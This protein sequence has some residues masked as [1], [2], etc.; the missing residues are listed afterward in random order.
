MVSRDSRCDRNRLK[1]FL[2]GDSPEGSHAE[3]LRH[4]DDCKVCQQELERLAADPK[5]WAQVRRFLTSAPGTASPG[6]PDVSNDAKTATPVEGDRPTA[7][8]DLALALL[9]PTDNP[10]MLGR[11][12]TYEVAEVVGR[13]GMGILFKAFDAELNRY[14]AIKVLA[15]QWAANAV[16]RRRFAREAQ[17]A[18]AVVHPNVMP[19]HAVSFVGEVPYLVMPYVSGL[20]LQ[21][22]IDQTGPLATTDILRIGMQ[23]AAGL[24][25]A[26]AQGLVHRDIKPGN[27]LLEN[28]V[29]R[30]LITDFG[31]AR[32]VDDA[33][34]TMTGS[35][36]G[37]PHYMSP[38]QAAGEAV[39]YRSD[40]FSLGSVLYE[41]CTGRPPFRARTTMAV[42]HRICHVSHRPVR[43]INPDIP[44]ELTEV[45]DRLLAKDPAQRLQSAAEVAQV[46]GQ[47]LAQLQQPTGARVDQLAEPPALGRSATGPQHEHG[48]AKPPGKPNLQEQPPRGRTW[49]RRHWRLALATVVLA[50][51][52]PLGLLILPSIVREAGS[53]GQRGA[54]SGRQALN[55]QIDTNVQTPGQDDF[56]SQYLRAGPLGHQFA[57]DFRGGRFDVNIFIPMGVESIY[58]ASLMVPEKK[59]LR[60]TIPRDQAPT[61]PKLGFAPAFEIHGDF[62][63]TASYEILALEPPGPEA[64]AGPNLYI[65][66]KT[67]LNGA[68]LRRSERPGGDAVYLIEWA[69]YSR[70][71]ERSLQAACF[72]AQGRSGKLRLARTG[73]MLHYLVAEEDEDQFHELHQVEFGTTPVGLLRVEAFAEGT[74]GTVDI[75]WNDLTVCAEQL[76]AIP[77]PLLHAP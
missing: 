17:A 6:K 45:I 16:N 73:N 37:T 71:G 14:V 23:T 77:L 72:P 57:Y 43:E 32:A 5:W 33:S 64:F 20:S 42:L 40:L 56:L 58:A 4:L 70:V 74:Q 1:A 24:A 47:L 49:I 39:D 63:I 44:G 67:T 46:L 54:K 69:V 2:E 22:R 10:A 31:L 48:Q 13:G 52:I 76:Q 21:A 53:P 59:G 26:H 38:E 3:I 25:A 61:K 66:A 55:T 68:T 41:M 34:L 11:L 15:P 75:R 19:I 18:A 30:V 12:D 35:V 50:S 29:E 7:Q 8:D 51:G 60:I 62:E 27:I 9:K 65:I 28:G 36:A